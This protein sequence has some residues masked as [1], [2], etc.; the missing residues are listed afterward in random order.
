M[1]AVDTSNSQ[2][3][4]TGEAASQRP[5]FFRFLLQL[6]KTD[7][8][9][10]TATDVAVIG[11]VV[12]FFVHPPFGW[13]DGGGL[14]KTSGSNR[15]TTSAPAN[16][17][18]STTSQPG[19]QPV[20]PPSSQGGA[21]SPSQ[22]ASPDE[23][24][25]GTIPFPKEVNLPTLAD[26][27]VF[28]DESAFTSSSAADKP[29]LAAAAR[30]WRSNQPGE[31][32]RALQGATVSDRNVTFVRALSM[33]RASEAESKQ[34]AEGLLRS[35][36]AA[37]Q[38][39][40]A[41]V[42]GSV[43]VAPPTGINKNA[44]EGRKLI[45]TAAAANEPMALRLSGIA[46]INAEFGSFNP[47]KARELLQKAIQA[48]DRYA[49]LFYAHMLDG[50]MAGPRDQKA[51]LDLLRQAAN[52]GLTAAQQA[53]GM[54][55][56]G[57]YRNKE[58]EDPNEGMEW[59]E[60]AALKGYS[61]EAVSS[62]ASTYGFG[63]APPWND[64]S[65]YYPLV[66][67]CAG[68]S[69]AWCQYQNGLAFRQGWGVERNL[70]RSYAHY[71]VA[72]Q[73]KHNPTAT[74]TELRLVETQLSAA[75][76]TAATAQANEIQA[77]LKPLP[78]PWPMQ[79]SDVPPPAAPW[80]DQECSDKD[81]QS[82]AS[83]TRIIGDSKQAPDARAA[84]LSKRAM[85]HRSAGDR[86]KA[87]ADLGEAIRLDPNGAV[88]YL[89]R[90]EQYRLQSDFDKALADLDAALRLDH[91]SA[92]AFYERAL[93]YH[94]GKN[95]YERAIA[96]YSEAIRL[97]PQRMAA[98][99]GR[100]QAY[101]A[102]KDYDRALADLGEAIRLNGKVPD[103]YF[104]RALVWE[105]KGDIDR[106][107]SDYDEVIKL[108]PRF[109][110]AFYNRGIM[111]SR[112]RDYDRAIADFDE[113][114]KLDGKRA[115]AFSARGNVYATKK[116]FSRAIEDYDAALRL[117]PTLSMALFR[118]GYAFETMGKTDAAIADY[119]QAVRINP[120]YAAAY[121][122]RAILYEKTDRIESAIADYRKA[123]SLDEN[124][125]TSREA[126]RR[127]DVAPVQ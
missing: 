35:A 127:L 30:A 27:P 40:A 51:A 125:R 118:R 33:L 82:L 98:W 36:A 31:I 77:A 46:A 110:N 107:I 90:G 126:L 86:D 62:L 97:E 20:A 58:T 63:R 71:L 73:L 99:R 15:A 69:S 43:L 11:A 47:V 95:E 50:G 19:T 9:F 53:L 16:P 105:H 68:F 103:S 102:T 96:D 5:S 48:G 17:A 117:N 67:L 80:A 61:I 104:R 12:L 72:Q 120:D 108:N 34:S 84:A 106:S 65:K 85:L 76:K 2:G 38:K 44:E 70:V 41:V 88:A 55:I 8:T 116:E 119:D 56:V 109:V 23:A 14:A 32:T 25:T 121:E 4:L 24:K 123:V 45:E 79:Y 54:W 66:R 122:R 21:Q 94:F 7:L 52:Q 91:R 89:R 13:F 59:L 26:Q 78:Q 28:I 111:Y 10:R 1:S 6:Y 57:R 37:G 101:H 115:D 112:K 75:D 100:G 113:T 39:Q 81:P 83:C 18:P 92:D 49:P 74:A 29:K 87:I 60:K 42:L 22:A 114:I 3:L 124:L 64:R 93:A